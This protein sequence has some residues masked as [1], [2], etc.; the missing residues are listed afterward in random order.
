VILTEL[1]AMMRGRETFPTRAEFEAQRREDL[2]DAIKSRGGS[3]LWAGRLGAGL[4]ERQKPGLSEEEA[5]ARAREVIEQLGRLPNEK[6]LR[7]MG[8]PKLASCVAASGGSKR[9]AELH[10]LD[11]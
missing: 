5:V 2:W 8:R 1:R 4:D 11:L 6:Q 10:E 9:F 3:R 7:R